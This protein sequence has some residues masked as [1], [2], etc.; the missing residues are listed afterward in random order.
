MFLEVAVLDVKTGQESA[1]EKSFGEAERIISSMDGHLGHRLKRCVER[2]SRYLL[3]VE[4]ARIEDHT[5]GFRNS[6]E[7][8]KW[9][10]LLHHF[11]ETPPQVEHYRDT[12]QASRPGA[13]AGET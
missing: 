13:A 10:A 11:Y 12:A 6:P 2:P 1:F 4:W 3:L 7:Y 5:Q 9:R 8:Q